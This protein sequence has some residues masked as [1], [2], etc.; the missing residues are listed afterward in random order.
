VGAIVR[1]EARLVATGSIGSRVPAT[2]SVG[3]RVEAMV[4]WAAVPAS[5]TSARTRGSWA[6][7]SPAVLPPKE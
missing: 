2:I 4:P 1:A 7:I 6:P 5:E 3:T